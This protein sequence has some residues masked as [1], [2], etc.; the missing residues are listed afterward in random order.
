MDAIKIALRNR[1][2]RA[3]RAQWLVWLSIVLGLPFSA[4]D[5]FMLS[6][7]ENDTMLPDHVPSLVDAGDVLALPSR[8]VARLPS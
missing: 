1:G 7:D 8:D 6:V 3:E 5:V 2:T 4:T